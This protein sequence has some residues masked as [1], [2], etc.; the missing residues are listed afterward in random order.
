MA[1]A[2]AWKNARNILAV[3]LDNLGDVLLC[4]PALRA[5]K[6]SR[7][8]A[9][10]TLLASP[11]G[12]QVAQI[13]ADIDEVIPYEA[14]WM[15]VSGQLPHTPGR[16]FALVEQIRRARFDGAII[17]TSYHQ[18]PLPAALLC[19]LAGVPLRHAASTDFP[20]SLLTS[21]HRHP[22]G[23]VHEVER[24]L[25]LVAGAGFE[26]RDDDL[27]AEIAS[28][29][30]AEL[31]AW[32]QSRGVSSGPLIAVHPGGSAPARIYPWEQYA[33]V[34]DL[35]RTELGARVVLTG[36]SGE[37]GL[38][39]RIGNA[40]RSAPLSLA[41]QTTLRQ[42]A[43]LFALAD[44]VITNNTGPMHLAA[45]LKRP[46]VALFAPTV[47]PQQWGP[48]KTAHRVLYQ[49]VSCA[50]CYR[51]VCPIDHPCL[52]GVPPERVVAAVVDLL[53]EVEA[54]RPTTAPPG[55][56]RSASASHHGPS[57][58]RHGP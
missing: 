29:D 54:S 51:F 14:P 42:L 30:L 43:A 39:E 9:R 56:A 12:A 58:A 1:V 44:V 34:V 27:V 36:T 33:R 57:E 24:A 6:R 41:G 17:F 40:A 16:E 11:T 49:P 15:D 48:W 10:L 20:G 19:Y 37:A 8:D 50:L 4:T 55:P 28:S 38:I 5:I 2:D 46:V 31:R 23:I 7:P 22:E 25:D 3:R 52:A 21:R 35:L 47:P 18:S 53:Q 32:L 26:A 13:D 45:A